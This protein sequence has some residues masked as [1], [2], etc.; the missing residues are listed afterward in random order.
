M[1]DSKNV[2]PQDN[3]IK[4]RCSSALCTRLLCIA[5][6]LNHKNIVP[7][8]A[9]LLSSEELRNYILRH[10]AD[11]IRQLFKPIEI[12]KVKQKVF[13]PIKHISTDPKLR[14]LQEK[15]QKEKDK[16]FIPDKTKLKIKVIN[17]TLESYVKQKHPQIISC[18]NDYQ[19]LCEAISYTI[20]MDIPQIYHDAMQFMLKTKDL[21]R[22]EGT[23]RGHWMSN[24]DYAI[25][26]AGGLV[27]T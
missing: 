6:F 26:R 3:P 19:I 10:D 7:C 25:N 16:Q 8:R 11:G 24:Q 12:E 4:I 18:R 20:G 1:N 2:L 17:S 23:E 14:R 13:R 22:I 27:R 9:F 21:V 15:K 5:S